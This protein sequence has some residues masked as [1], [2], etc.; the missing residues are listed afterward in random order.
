MP[1]A[2]RLAFQFDKHVQV[3]GAGLFQN[4]AV[5]VSQESSRRLKALVIGGNPHWVEITYEEGR[6]LVSCECPYFE[7]YGYC[8]H[9]WAALLEADRRGALTEAL[10]AKY[11]TLDD[12][13][14]VD[15]GPGFG[16]GRPFQLRAPSP[17]RVPAWEE[18]LTVIRRELEHKKSK[19]APWPRE[20]EIIYV[21]D[22]GASRSAAAIVIEL[23]SRTRKKN[24]EWS[25][26]KDLRLRPRRRRRFRIRWMRRQLRPCSAAKSII[27][28]TTT[29]PATQSRASPF[30]SRWP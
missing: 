23:F 17:S 15:D 26:Q 29:P 2:S 6:L 14:G 12:G 16:P 5:R 11:L 20:F 28:I 8:K 30:R 18:Q 27:H 19:P 7:E 21:L 9:I 10:A 22:V 13:S 24:G 1:L 4:R 3:R 25:A